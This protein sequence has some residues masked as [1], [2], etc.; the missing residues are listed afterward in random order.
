MKT[1]Y[2][3]TG[4]NIAVLVTVYADIQR[5]GFYDGLH[6]LYVVCVYTVAYLLILKTKELSGL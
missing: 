2:F 4:M 1:P 3:F 6:C 5:L